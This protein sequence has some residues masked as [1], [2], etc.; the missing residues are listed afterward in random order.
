[1]FSKKINF[2]VLSLAVL[3]SFGYFSKSS[4]EIITSTLTDTYTINLNG[5]HLNNVSGLNI[6]VKLPRKQAD[7]TTGVTFTSM[8]AN[9]LLSTVTG[10][11][12]EE[13]TISLVLTGMITDG[14]ATI[15]GKFIDNSIIPGAEF[16]VTSITQDGGLDL[17]NLLTT[18]IIFSNS[19]ATPTPTPTATPSA[20]ATPSDS[21]S[22]TATPTPSASISAQAQDIID[23]IS[24]D[25]S[26]IDPSE[27]QEALV[28]E[29]DATVTIKTA[30]SIQLKKNG[31]NKLFGRLNGLLGKGFT[32]SFND[33]VSCV[34]F[35]FP[36][37]LKI[38]NPVFS[39]SARF[40][41]NT[42]YRFS[43]RI[44]ASILPDGD[45]LKLLS[46]E[47]DSTK[48]GVVP[49]CFAYRKSDGDKAL[50]NTANKKGKPIEN[51][52]ATEYFIG[53]LDGGADI[54]FGDLTEVT[55]LAPKAA[56]VHN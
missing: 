10:P 16:L 11:S 54:I 43:K 20:T 37:Y 22:V 7:I 23:L 56:N 17:T 26:D 35:S 27:I 25:G 50:Q 55:L 40:N 8:G 32:S 42:K 36:S 39:A 19:K 3:F 53:I 30:D 47:I 34:V 18:E 52:T 9:V 24:E 31:L 38:Q 1:M 49:I 33:R 29:G 46:G 2:I 28:D 44:A 51:F 45:G 41:R 21:G 13:Y 14:K 48:V 5:I 12:A 6:K 15:T 4:A